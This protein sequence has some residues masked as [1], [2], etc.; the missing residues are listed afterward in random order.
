M[1]YKSFVNFYNFTQIE[2]SV[3]LNNSV[4]N[5]SNLKFGLNFR[6]PITGKLQLLQ[7]FELFYQFFSVRPK[8]RTIKKFGKSTHFN[9]SLHIRGVNLINFFENLYTIRNSSRRKLVSFK[10][11]S[12]DLFITMKD[13]I[14]LY[15]FNIRFYDFHSWRFQVVLTA[16][17]YD[18][19]LHE[20]FIFSNFF[21][22]FFRYKSNG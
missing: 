15:P 6:L 11:K 17:T 2:N 13:F 19:S 18:Y 4:P 16:A 7:A 3:L 12:S 9:V 20:K 5:F 1:F 22:N 21:N 8:I 10:I 14:T